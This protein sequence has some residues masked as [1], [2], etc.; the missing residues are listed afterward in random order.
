MGLDHNVQLGLF[1]YLSDQSSDPVPCF[2][3]TFGDNSP[4]HEFKSPFEASDGGG[5]RSGLGE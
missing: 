1:T 5:T 3:S 4:G 2:V